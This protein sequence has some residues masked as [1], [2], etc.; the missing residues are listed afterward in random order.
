MQVNIG[1]FGPYILHSKKFYSIPKDQEP[2]DLNQEQAIEIILA[3]RKK[4]AEKTIKVFDENPDVK[5]LN[6]RWGP[7]IAFEKQ[8]VKI[9]KGTDPE[10]GIASCRERVCQYVS[11]SVVA[12]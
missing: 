11:I 4:D 5:V 3:K 9:P 1:R 7:F 2:L 10:I 8:N 6:G 12:V